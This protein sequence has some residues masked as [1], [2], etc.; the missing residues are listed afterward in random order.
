MSAP[1]SINLLPQ[2]EFET[3]FW[4]KLLTWALS[5]GRYVIILTELVVIIAFIS[6]FKL[7]QDL[8]V[9]SEKI[10]GQKN[11]LR[12]SSSYET[13]FRQVQTKITTAKKK[14]DTQHQVTQALD[15]VTSRVIT[16]VKLENINVDLN[17]VS[18]TGT[19]LDSQIFGNFVTR[20]SISP[21]WKSID[22]SNISQTDTLGVKFT[23]SAKI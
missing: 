21:Q 2:S 3:S 18:V 11:V 19:A 10:S 14:L 8:Q 9:L 6:R 4:G 5:T 12:A 23:I 16:G 1:R 22:L 13:R 20:F 15:L 17:G 7:D